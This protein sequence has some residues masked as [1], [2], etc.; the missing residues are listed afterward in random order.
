[1]LLS[2][3]QPQFL[4]T[5]L[6]LH[7][8]LSH[9]CSTPVL[10]AAVNS[11]ATFPEHIA[12]S[13]HNTVSP[14]LHTCPVCC[15]QQHSHIFC[16]YCCLSTQQCLNTSPHLSCLL[17]SEAQPQFL[18]TL[19]PLHTTLS[20]RRSTPVL[21]PAVR[22]TATVPEHIAASPHNN[23]SPPLH[24]CSFCYCQQHSHSS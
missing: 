9:H 24:T 6:P 5:L 20:H 10:F 14:L 11:T 17:L 19:S 18:N 12:A 7:T 2:T 15:C 8:T 3:A 16:I 22:S 1:M 4:N 23:V 21:F 13:P